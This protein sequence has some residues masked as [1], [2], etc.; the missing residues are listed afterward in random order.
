MKHIKSLLFVLVILLFSIKTSYVTAQEMQIM[1][2]QPADTGPILGQEHA[3]SVLFRGNGDAVVTM[4]AAFTNEQQAQADTMSFRIPRAQPRRIIAFQIIREPRCVRY[5]P[6]E[7]NE[8]AR[9]PVCIQ[10]QKP[11]YFQWYGEAKYQKADT[12]FNGDTLTIAFPQPVKPDESGSVL[13]VFSASDY[14]KRDFFGARRYAFETFKIE[15]A[16]IVKATVGVSV[17]SD[18]VLAGAKGAVNYRWSETEV[19]SLSPAVDHAGA[20]P[21]LDQMYGRVGY[22]AITKSASHLEPLESYTV[23]GRYADSV[24]RLYAKH[25]LIALG[26]MLAA[27][28][29]LFFLGKT[30]FKDITEKSSKAGST[31]DTALAIAGSFLSATLIIIYTAALFYL[32][33]AVPQSISREAFGFLFVLI[34]VISVG[35][36]GFLLVA[37][38]IM[39]GIR[40]GL[41]WG[42]GAF[43]L[44]V[45][46]LIINAAIAVIVLAALSENGTRR[47]PIYDIMGRAATKTVQKE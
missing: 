38:S 19:M 46:F 36:Y 17:D 29:I 20:S 24:L 22:G 42:L 4:R 37:P 18:L 26:V 7:P 10:Y 43:A 32:R 16:S 14:T 12:S 27:L 8:R 35:L 13:V 1:P 11:N 33:N 28:V 47:L 21:Q 40:R 45:F 41:A 34:A 25:A 5:K 30:A 15:G 44:T 31:M 3:Y 9:A 39:M 2:P 6:N 23:R